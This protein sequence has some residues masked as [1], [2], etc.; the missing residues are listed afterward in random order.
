MKAT[1]SG[2]EQVKE[3]GNRAFKSENYYKAILFYEEG[4][5]RAHDFNKKHGASLPFKNEI[6]E[7]PKLEEGM[8]YHQDFA[9]M[10]AILYN[11]ISTS[12]FHLQNLAKAD[13]FNDMALME[14]PDYARALLRKILILEK[15]GEYGAGHGLAK[16]AC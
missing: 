9:R 12:Y 11:N 13:A 6:G 2:I 10:K 8:I 15:K 3:E 14:D 16:F 5:R 1:I 4:I 7:S